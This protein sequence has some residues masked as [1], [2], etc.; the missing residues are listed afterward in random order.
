MQGIDCAEEFVLHVQ[1]SPVERAALSVTQRTLGVPLNGRQGKLWMVKQIVFYL[2]DP[3]LDNKSLT[4]LIPVVCRLKKEA[5]FLIIADQL[6]RRKIVIAL[7]Q[8]SHLEIG[9]DNQVPVLPL[10]KRLHN[11]LRHATRLHYSRKN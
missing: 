6:L 1:L 2:F 11:L 5:H 7:T 8:V 4:V 10:L 9:R 3:F